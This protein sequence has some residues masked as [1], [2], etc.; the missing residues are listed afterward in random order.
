M[1]KFASA[2]AA[3]SV[4]Y[5]EVRERSFTWCNGRPGHK[6][7]N[8]FITEAS[9]WAAEQE[10]NGCD[11]GED[12]GFLADIIGGA[13]FLKDAGTSFTE[14]DAPAA[15]APDLVDGEDQTARDEKRPSIAL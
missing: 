12:C 2:R 7:R 10:A 5:K 11:W 8:R 4:A 9:E 13:M 3:E 14:P 1:S 15:T 6:E